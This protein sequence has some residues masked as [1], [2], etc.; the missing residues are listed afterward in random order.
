MQNKITTAV[1]VIIVGIAA[2]YGGM[3][4]ATP[5]SGVPGGGG[6]QLARGQNGSTT[7]NGFRGARGDGQGGFVSGE[8]IAKDATSIT[9]KL[10]DGGSKIVLLSP[11]TQVMKTAAGTLAD[12]AVGVQVSTTGA[13]NSDGSVTAQSVQIRPA[14]V[15]R[16]GQTQ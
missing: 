15:N 14:G 2:F 13:A 11:S 16:Q 4:Y 1:I 3:S 10:R 9:I 5:A 7:Q 12:L 6:T 8:V